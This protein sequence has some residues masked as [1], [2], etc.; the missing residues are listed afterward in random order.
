[1]KKVQH[2]KQ[3]SQATTHA[4]AA[5]KHPKQ[6]ALSNIVQTE[7]AAALKLRVGVESRKQMP[8]IRTMRLLAFCSSIA[9]VTRERERVR[10]APGTRPTNTADAIFHD[11]T[12]LPV[13]VDVRVTATPALTDVQTHLCA[14]E[15]AKRREYGSAPADPLRLLF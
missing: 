10:Y 7:I 13:C 14:Q 3:C 12:G 11:L 5:C 2:A 6:D 8:W 9:A 15:A 1:M 4:R